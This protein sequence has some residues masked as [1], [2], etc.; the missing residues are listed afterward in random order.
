MQY[1]LMTFLSEHRPPDQ[2]CLC[3]CLCLFSIV[4]LRIAV[5]RVTRSAAKGTSATGQRDVRV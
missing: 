2:M 1:R 5:K 4:Y 3:I